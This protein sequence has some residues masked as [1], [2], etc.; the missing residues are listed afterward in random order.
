ME[1][2][3]LEMAF[4][5]LAAVNPSVR[6]KL[7]C[8]KSFTEKR[9]SPFLAALIHSQNFLLTEGFT[10]QRR[11]K[12]LEQKKNY[13]ELAYHLF[14]DTQV[15]VRGRVQLQP[16]RSVTPLFRLPRCCCC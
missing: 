10:A 16:E 13:L 5:V 9:K 3:Q 2:G 15:R 1:T 12:N 14:F 11:K 7:S 4:F 6:R 8:A